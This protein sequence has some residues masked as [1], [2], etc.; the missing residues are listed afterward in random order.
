FRPKSV[1]KADRLPPRTKKHLASSWWAINS[2]RIKSQ[3]ILSTE[4]SDWPTHFDSTASDIVG[5][6]SHMTKS[7][8]GLRPAPLAKGA[9]TGCLYSAIVRF[10]LLALSIC[11]IGC[12]RYFSLNSPLRSH[13]YSKCNHEPTPSVRSLA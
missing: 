2:S 5:Y 3:R 10:A 6:D 13:R 7:T 8:S 1:S 12:A 11:P 9:S 4:G